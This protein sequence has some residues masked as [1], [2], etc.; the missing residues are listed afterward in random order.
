MFKLLYYEYCILISAIINC[1]TEKEDNNTFL[2]NEKKLNEGTFT[3]IFHVKFNKNI[4]SIRVF[5]WNG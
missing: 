4:Y 3:S 5:L 1:D 2:E